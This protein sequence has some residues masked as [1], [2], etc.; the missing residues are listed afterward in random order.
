LVCAPG[1]LRVFELGRAVD[2]LTPRKHKRRLTEREG[3][4]LGRQLTRY[5]DALLRRWP[6]E[7]EENCW[8][9]ALVVYRLLMVEGAKSRILF[10]VRMSGGELLGHAWVE[11][12]GVA[13][14]GT[15][16]DAFTPTFVWPLPSEKEAGSA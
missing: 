13:V 11:T 1:L 4:I 7:I 9:R 3:A 2:L 5:C 15:A 16:P 10:G 12:G 6:R 8:R 14:D